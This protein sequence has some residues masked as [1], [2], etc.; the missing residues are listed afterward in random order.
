MKRV[1]SIKVLN[2]DVTTPTKASHTRQMRQSERYYKHS[3]NVCTHAACLA[4]NITSAHNPL[5]KLREVTPSQMLFSS[6]KPLWSGMG[7]VV[8][9]RTSLTL[10]P[11]SPPTVHQLSWLAL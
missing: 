4:N 9:A 10:H 1:T 7:E 5:E 6:L 11:P 3:P 8:L 2:Y